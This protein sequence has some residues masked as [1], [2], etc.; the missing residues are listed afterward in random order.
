[1]GHVD[2]GGGRR[3]MFES[4][5]GGV[6]WEGGCGSEDKEIVDLDMIPCVSKTQQ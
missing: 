3:D 6:H 5:F 4:V 1:M 2:T